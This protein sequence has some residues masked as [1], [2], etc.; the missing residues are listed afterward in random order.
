MRVLLD[1]RSITRTGIGSYTRMLIYG[2]LNSDDI[3]LTLMGSKE[4]IDKFFKNISTIETSESI[5]SLKEQIST[6]LAEKRSKDVDL[7]HYVNYNKSFLSVLP[8]VVTIHDLIQFKFNYGSTLKN[9]VAKNL[10]KNSIEKASAVICVSENTRKELLEL[11]PNISSRTFVVYNPALNPLVSNYS[12]VD[13]KKKY[14][15][16]K[17]I[18]C[19][20]IRKPHKNFGVVV[21]ALGMLNKD[22]PNLYL[23]I[24]GKKFEVYDYLDEE[25]KNAGVGNRVVALDGVFYD[26]LISFYK[27]AEI[28]VLSSLAEGFGLV[29]F[30]SI[31]Q[32]TL[33]LVSDIPVMRELFFEENEIF[34]DPYSAES[35]SAKLSY[36]LEKPYERKNLVK[37]LGKYLS[38]YSFERFITETK[39]IYQKVF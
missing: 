14:G 36:F 26:E 27:D 16:E 24:I 39:N 25:I 10:M 37:K 15:I 12:Y 3:H 32:G 38:I 2:L 19:V 33:P 9:A 29:P 6:F 17:Y 5:Y 1:A 31:Q 34:F 20:G 21:R 4:S 7:V 23:V 8:Y 11:Y 13:V 30:E 28:T 35:L 18:L 22:Y